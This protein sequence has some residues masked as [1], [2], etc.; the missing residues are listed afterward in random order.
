ML[1]GMGTPLCDRLL[2]MDV[3]HMELRTVKLSRDPACPV[4][5][6]R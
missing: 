2:V 5:S 6:T 4:C 3:L 1:V